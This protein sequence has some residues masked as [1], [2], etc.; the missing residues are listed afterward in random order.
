MKELSLH[1]RDASQLLA[2]VLRSLTQAEAWQPNH[3]LLGFIDDCCIRL[4]KKAVKYHQDLLE[5]LATIQIS[6]KRDSG[7]PGGVLL[8]VIMEQWPFIEGVAIAPDLE[9]ISRWL[10]R[11]LLVLKL[12]DGDSGLLE[13]VRDRVQSMTA[14]KKC[15]KLLKESSAEL[16]D[17]GLSDPPVQPDNNVLQLSRTLQERIPKGVPAP[18]DVWQPPTPPAPENENHPGLGRWK[19][20]DIEEAIAE[21][22]IGDLILCLCS[23]HAD[24]RKQALIEVRAWMRK[25]QVRMPFV[26][27]LTTC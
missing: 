6:A 7:H 16:F 27:R 9:N 22:A 24:I 21:G 18:Q 5:Q 10:S 2:A 13:H 14:T 12:N 19:H 17:N 4:S 15:R 11:F 8:M 20:L 25:L 3:T 23:R 26:I 1:S